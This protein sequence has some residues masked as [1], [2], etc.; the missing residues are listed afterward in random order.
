MPDRYNPQEHIQKLE[1]A[2]RSENILDQREITIHSYQ[3]AIPFSY[4]ALNASLEKAWLTPQI[5]FGVFSRIPISDD[6]A[7]SVVLGLQDELAIRAY[8]YDERRPLWYSW[9]NSVVDTINVHYFRDEDGLLRF[10]TAGGGRRITESLLDSFNSSFLEIPKDAVT[11]RLFD[12]GKLR[13]LCFN[14]FGDRLYKIRFSDPAAK[15]Y[16]SIDHASFQSRKYIDASVERL[17]EIRADTKVTI[18]SFESDADV[19]TLDL[20]V[21]IQV[22][23]TIRGLSGSLKLSFPKI[24]YKDQLASAEQQAIVFYRLADATVNVILD[25]D[26]Y[27]HQRRSLNDLPS[28]LG[29][30]RDVIEL[31]PFREVLLRADACDT[32]FSQ[33]DLF[34]NWKHW[35]PHLQAIGELIGMPSVAQCV[36]KNVD[37]LCRRDPRMTTRLLDECRA[38]HK[39]GKLGCCVAKSLASVLQEIPINLRQAA[40]ESLLAW[41]VENDSES[42][43]VDDATAVV[44]A[45]GHQWRADDFSIEIL[46]SILW[47]LVGVIHARLMN[48]SGDCSALLRKL[49]WCRRVAENLARSGSL[50][51]GAFLEMFRKHVRF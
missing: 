50:R 13:D 29:M 10:T 16:R 43:D 33:M 47:K 34:S 46:A 17:I 15:E 1:I 3:A 45:L 24:R 9:Q 7:L 23:F 25:A 41:A 48:T 32:F 38:D 20:A 49:E 36:Q 42:W 14:R 4:A 27:T 40:E 5:R 31:A 30:F 28:D 12:L 51:R 37:A 19:T 2:P 21:P 26:Y 11:K 39:I 18:E 44:S 35:S 22:R 6:K 8:D